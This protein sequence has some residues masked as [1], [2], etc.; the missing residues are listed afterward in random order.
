MSVDKKLVKAFVQECKE[1]QEWKERWKANHIDF[2]NYFKYSGKVEEEK[3]LISHWRYDFNHKCNDI[4]EQFIKV[5]EYEKNKKNTSSLSKGPD[6]YNWN[7][8]TNS[9]WSD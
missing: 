8:T 9:V 6:S 2:N 3:V 1:E 7:E 5:K 4:H